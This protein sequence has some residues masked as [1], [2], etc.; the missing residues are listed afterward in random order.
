MSDKPVTTTH[1]AEDE[2]PTPFCEF[3]KT[4]CD[5]QFCD[6]YGCAKKEGFYDDEE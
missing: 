6:D 3:T 2:A 1:E 4:Y 5:G